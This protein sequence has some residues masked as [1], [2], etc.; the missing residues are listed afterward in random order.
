[1]TLDSAVSDTDNTVKV[2]YTKPTSGNTLQNRP[3][4]G[5]GDAPTFDDQEV[6]NNTPPAFSTASVDGNVLSVA[7]NE[8][9]DST[10]T[11]GGSAFE[12]TATARNA[13]VRT[14]SGTGTVEIEDARRECRSCQSA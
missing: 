7:F 1:M 9:L 4:D 11:P 3:A 5:S 2:R 12:V 10:S 14:L 13:T 6:T 8:N